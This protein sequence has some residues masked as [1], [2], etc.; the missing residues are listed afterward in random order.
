MKEL[1]AGLLIRGRKNT[2]RQIR[3]NMMEKSILKGF[4]SFSLIPERELTT[5]WEGLIGMCYI[6]CDSKR[7]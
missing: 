3:S 6:G 7:T 5:F 2:V 4:F 1:D